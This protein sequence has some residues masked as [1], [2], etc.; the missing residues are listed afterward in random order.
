MKRFFYLIFFASLLFLAYFPSLNAGFYLDD[1]G[2]I[3]NNGLIKAPVDWQRIIDVYGLRTLPYSLF[4]I[5]Y[6]AF[7][8]ST[9]GYHLVSLFIHLANCLLVFGILLTLLK[10]SVVY[11]CHD[12]S[13]HRGNVN[14][15]ACAIVT[16]IFAFHPQNSQAVIYI[17][18]QIALIAT[19]FSL[20]SLYA[21]LNGRRASDSKSQFLWL[22]LSLIFFIAAML[23]KQNVAVLPLVFLLIELLIIKRSHYK[24]AALF[25]FTG[26]FVVLLAYFYA[27]S[28]DKLFALI[29]GFTRENS[30]LT[31]LE[32]FYT[33]LGVV[34]HYI[35]Q[36]YIPTDFRLEYDVAIVS[37]FSVTEL[38]YLSL[39]IGLI[40]IASSL[41][42]KAPLVSLAVFSFYI[43]HLVE[44]SFIPIRDVAFEHRTYLPN[45]MQ[46][47]LI[48]Y[49]LTALFSINRLREYLILLCIIIVTTLLLIT[50]E[51]AK[52]WAD[53][54]AFYKNEISISKRNPRLYMSLGQMYIDNDQCHLALSYFDHAIRLYDM[55]HESNLG[56][57]PEL[58]QNY[59]KCL[60]S[61]GMRQQA[62][63]LL[64]KLLKQV[65]RS[66]QE[67]MLYAQKGKMLMDLK[68]HK[69][70]RYWLRKAYQLDNKQIYILVNL[71]IC[72]AVLKNFNAAKYLLESAL[73]VNPSH[74]MA[75]ELLQKVNRVVQSSDS[76][77]VNANQ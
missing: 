38:A 42:R 24:F 66:N 46:S 71:A 49:V 48:A 69:K 3:V 51:R 7:Q 34:A 4:A 58:F 26:L 45:I 19:F 15:L 16:L 27:G 44:S 60:F 9:L 62:F 57:Q 12:N 1:F 77:K 8:D 59:A 63:N 22:A 41:T 18:Q 14:L 64:D 43:L 74:E 35:K 5:Q 13:T 47:V 31:R 37:E 54:F 65:K 6:S 20:L 75:K 68:M 40:L 11:K 21:F 50:H 33:Q 10:V 73:V 61:L 56:K 29:D 28:L 39:H 53:Q 36:F 52:L 70:A 25:T 67:A 55:A 23:S 17:V 2:S 76:K 30:E 72:E 32:Y